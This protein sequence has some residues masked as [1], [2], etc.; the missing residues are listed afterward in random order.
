MAATIGIF[1]FF[2]ASYMLDNF[3]K[4]SDLLLYIN[5][6]FSLAHP[7]R[8]DYGFRNVFKETKMVEF[9]KKKFC[10]TDISL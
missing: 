5:W 6:Y 7:I 3:I 9:C 10:K 1:E 8:C 4:Y 2:I